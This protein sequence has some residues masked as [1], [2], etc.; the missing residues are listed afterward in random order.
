MRYDEVAS[1]GFG[2]TAG[3]NQRL[4]QGRTVAVKEPCWGHVPQNKK[5]EEADRVQVRISCSA[6]YWRDFHGAT[7]PHR[8]GIRW[9]P[10]RPSITETGVEGE[11]GSEVEEYDDRLSYHSLSRCCLGVNVEWETW[12]GCASGC[13][14]SSLIISL[15]IVWASCYSAF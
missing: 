3:S 5:G 8:S 10:A 11:L 2:K 14:G 12:I 1:A 9:V 6:P 7:W 13:L 15:L 4:L